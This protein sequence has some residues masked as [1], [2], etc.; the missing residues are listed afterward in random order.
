MNDVS[1]L[2]A[3]WHLG[4]DQVR[5]QVYRAATP[6]ERERGHALWLL[7]RDWP[8]S[9]VAEAVAKV[10]EVLERFFAGLA[11]RGDEVKRR[12]R[13]ALQAQADTFGMPVDP[14]PSQ[15]AHVD[16]IVESV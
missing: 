1:A 12:G 15:T 10:R 9:Q 8:A 4:T 6:R 5:E 11:E 7:A 3:H 13:R 16:F 2:L 14:S